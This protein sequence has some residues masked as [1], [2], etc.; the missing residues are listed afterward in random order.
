VASTCH[1]C[2]GSGEVPVF[3]GDNLPEQGAE[4][5]RVADEPDSELMRLWR[6]AE[7]GRHAEDGWHFL[8]CPRC[9]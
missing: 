5:C 9:K 3:C 7:R 8:K 1:L 6:I 4:E 2:E